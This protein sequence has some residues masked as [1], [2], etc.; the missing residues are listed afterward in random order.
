MSPKLAL[1][2]AIDNLSEPECQRLLLLVNHWHASIAPAMV[3]LTQN[4]T[5]RIPTQSFP[6]FAPV[7]PILGTGINASAQLI[8][9]RH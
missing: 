9:E 6:I 2:Q 8:E 7:S 3:R 1:H 5:F 4:P